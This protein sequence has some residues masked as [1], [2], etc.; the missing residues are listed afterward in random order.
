MKEFGSEHTSVVPHCASRSEVA[1]SQVAV[2]L[3]RRLAT[4]TA[5]LSWC[6]RSGAVWLVEPQVGVRLL[7]APTVVPVVAGAVIGMTGSV[8]A[9]HATSVAPAAETQP[10]SSG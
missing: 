10:R 6:T 3:T 7:E 5:R 8:S 2:R 9:G 1:A 4:G